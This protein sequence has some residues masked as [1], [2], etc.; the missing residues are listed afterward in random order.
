MFIG[1]STRI[2]QVVVLTET[3]KSVIVLIMEDK[4]LSPTLRRFY[5]IVAQGCS[6][7]PGK[8][9]HKMENEQRVCVV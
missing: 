5:S 6:D 2:T 7:H 4:L 8:I 3:K 1:I 9:C